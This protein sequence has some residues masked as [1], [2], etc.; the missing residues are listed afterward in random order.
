M[1]VWFVTQAS[2][3]LVSKAPHRQGPSTGRFQELRKRASSVSPV[4]KGSIVHSTVPTTRTRSLS[5]TN[6]R[7]RSHLPAQQPSR[8]VN[9]D[10]ISVKG[11]RA[12]PSNEA[13][14]NDGAISYNNKR[15][16]SVEMN[17]ASNPAKFSLKGLKSSTAPGVCSAVC[18]RDVGT[19]PMLSDDEIF[20]VLPGSRGSGDASTGSHL[21]TQSSRSTP[22]FG[23]GPDGQPCGGSPTHVNLPINS[24]SEVVN[25]ASGHDQGAFNNADQNGHGHSRNRSGEFS[26]RGEATT[27]S[28]SQT[29]QS[30]TADETPQATF[31]IQENLNPPTL[32]H[33]PPPSYFRLQEN[34]PFDV[35][36]QPSSVNKV[37]F[38]QHQFFQDAHFHQL[39]SH[40][41]GPPQHVAQQHYGMCS[42][43]LGG[44]ADSADPPFSSEGV[45][46]RGIGTRGLLLPVE[47]GM[48]NQ[49]SSLCVDPTTLRV[50]VDTKR[51]EMERCGGNGVY[52]MGGRLQGIRYRDLP[53]AVIGGEQFPITELSAQKEISDLRKALNM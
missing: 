33:K 29:T 16:T 39:N 53:L 31:C 26:K 28:T 13:L 36:G 25:S 10:A 17:G 15:Q 34:A 47:R 19:N 46:T 43:I 1:A 7:Q 51:A 32:Q 8:R 42:P 5:P 20:S 45:V 18:H 4:R 41:S 3:P 50:Q 49:G 2:P 22:E 14:L 37:S 12:L 44:R 38:Q 24:G 27:V 9:T 11:T 48:I 40:L 35:D 30:S 21:P 23:V 6:Q 52:D